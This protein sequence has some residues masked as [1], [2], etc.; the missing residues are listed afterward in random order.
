[1][2]RKI[3][4]LTGLVGISAL[5]SFSIQPA[6]AQQ[7]PEEISR[8]VVNESVQSV[9]QS[10]RDQIQRRLAPAAAV[11]RPLRFSADGNLVEAYYDDV[12][13]ALGYAKSSMPT[14][15]TVASPAMSGPPPLMWGVSVTGSIDQQRATVA[16]LSATADTTS[17]V[18]TGD[19]TKIGVFTSSDAV[20]IGVNGSGSRTTQDQI[21]AKSSG[22]GTFIAYINGGFSA[23]FEFNA[24]FTSSNTP[25]VTI[26][27]IPVSALAT[28]ISTDTTAY[29]Y[30][31]NVQY[32]FDL[33]NGWWIEPTIGVSFSESF[34]STAGASSAQSTLIQGGARFGTDVR[35][36]GILVQ[37]TFTGIAYSFIHESVGGIPSVVAVPTDEGQLWGRGAAKLNFIFNNNF[38][39]FIEGNIR[40]TGGTVDAIGYGGLLGARVTF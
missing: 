34:F 26:A 31:G 24:T 5:S 35:W 4:A 9:I 8:Q 28:S 17:V 40:G 11:N 13:G 19:V 39:A 10:I 22:V 18:G 25:S 32:K 15:A 27:G 36:N 16:G 20:V 1:M 14:K 23:D 38:S 21:E 30:S 7:R 3:T 33:A 2:I 12:F 6:N 29:S 37:P